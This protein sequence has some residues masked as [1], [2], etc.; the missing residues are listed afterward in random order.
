MLSIATF[1]TKGYLFAWPQ[2]IRRVA[3]AV[4]HLDG[5]NFIF[6]T[7]KSKEAKEAIRVVEKEF[8]ANWNIH[9]IEHDMP[10]D[11][12][13]NYKLEAQLRI[14]ILQGSAFSLAR[15]LKSDFCW[16]IESD[17]LVPPDALKISQWVLN[18][19]DQYYD[20]AMVTYPNSGFLGGRGNY[21]HPIAE[22]WLLHERVVPERLKNRVEI[23][24]KIAQKQIKKNGK[25]SERWM[26]I[27]TKL[28]KLVRECP[29]DGNVFA[30]NGKYGW[31]QRGWF[32]NAYPG[33]GRGAIVPT[34]WVG[35]GC[36]LLSKRALSLATFEGYDGK[37]TQDLFLCFKRW[38]PDGINMACIPH[39]LCDHVK[40]ERD[41]NN[42][43]TDKIIHMKSWH[44][45][46]GECIGHL[47]IT[48]IPW[49]SL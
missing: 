43:R 21:Q 42:N 28:D 17:I 7:D 22:D 49:I 44:E 20:V 12:S 38:K 14:A 33:I 27:K 30:I 36:T 34:D 2:M 32:E 6:S 26:R 3:A 48:S 47:R 45:S 10:D 13:E 41:K 8:P 9:G 46:E 24:D 31:R 18:M 11:T 4:S 29:P 35:L 37:G 16:S 25:I 40:P 19:P 5:G 39:I 23:H 1:A 15:K